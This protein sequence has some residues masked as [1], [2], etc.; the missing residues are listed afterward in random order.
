[1]DRDSGSAALEPTFCS[2]SLALKNSPEGGDATPPW[3]PT[4]CPNLTQSLNG[5]DGPVTVGFGEA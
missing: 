5:P 2:I 4:F 3:P 1:M